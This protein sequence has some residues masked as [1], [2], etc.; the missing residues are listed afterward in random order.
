[1]RRFVLFACLCLAA[2]PVR[3]WEFTPTPVC[4]LRND[5]PLSVR[6][7][8]DPRLDEPYA[9][10]L[11]SDA[12]W[13]VGAVFGLSFEGPRGLTITTG[14]HRLSDDRLSLT[15]TDRG[16]GNV[17]NGLEFNTAASAF[18]G[19]TDRR[20]ALDGAAEPVRAFRSCIAAP[21]A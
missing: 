2:G 7:T 20:F 15:V 12:P 13:P 18:V 5:G 17:L 9:I 19:D 4:T 14:R 3:A 6:V 16:F 10:T 11:T 8:F 21:V 1:M